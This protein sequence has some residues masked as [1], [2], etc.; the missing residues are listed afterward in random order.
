MKLLDYQEAAKMLRCEPGSL[1]KKVMLGLVPCIKLFGKK[2]RTFFLAE[3]LE[4]FIH[5]KRCATVD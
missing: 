4:K 2:G 3:D 1:R 5:S